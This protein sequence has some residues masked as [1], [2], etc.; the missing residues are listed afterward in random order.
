MYTCTIHSLYADHFCIYY[1]INSYSTLHLYRNLKG[2]I[3]GLQANKAENA[4]V[5]LSHC[6]D[7]VMEVKENFH[8]KI[9]PAQPSTLHS[10]A[11]YMAD[12]TS[13]IE[14]LSMSNVF[15]ALA[16]QPPRKHSA[17]PKFSPLLH[18]VNEDKLRLWILKTG[19]NIML[20]NQ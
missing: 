3:S 6:L 10:S 14:E 15:V 1:V 8:A 17:M 13:V 5:R 11:K 7:V 4:I 9:N 16:D 18:R 19:K 20:N 12:L 2:Y